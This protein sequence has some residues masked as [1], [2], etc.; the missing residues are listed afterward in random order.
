MGCAVIERRIDA[1]RIRRNDFEDGSGLE[2][3]CAD[4]KHGG[5]GDQ[6]SGIRDRGSGIWGLGFSKDQPRKNL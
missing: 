2:Q 3:A 6:G 5:V 1:I 4:P